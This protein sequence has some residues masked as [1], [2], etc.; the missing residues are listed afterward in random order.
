MANLTGGTDNIYITFKKP[1]LTL[2]A[3]KI[4]NDEKVKFE[5]NVLQQVNKTPDVKNFLKAVKDGNERMVKTVLKSGNKFLPIFNG[6]RWTQIDK[7][8]FTLQDNDTQKQELGSLLAIQRGIENNGYTDKSKFFKLYREEL[9][10]VYPEMN[11]KWEETFFQQQLTVYRKVGPTKFSH[12]SRDGGFMD[13]ITEVAKNNYG[14]TRKDTWNPADIWLVSDYQKVKK[15]LDDAIKDDS[16]S[17]QEFNEILRK[18][19]RDKK[20]IGISLKLISGTTAK[21]EVVN[22]EKSDLFDENEYQ[23]SFSS[24][25]LDLQLKTNNKEFNNTDSKIFIEGK[26]KVKF[27]IRQNSAG[28]NN[29]KIEGTDVGASS[30][31]LGKV[32]LD[33]ATQVFKAYGLESMR[34]RKWQNYPSNADEYNDE[35]KTHEKRFS[36]LKRRNKVSFGNVSNQT[37]FSENIIAVFNEKPDIANSKLMQLDLLNEIFSLTG[38]KLDS[39]LTNLAFL[40]QKKGDVFGPFAKLY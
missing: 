25:E 6:Y 7:G 10:S 29:L 38:D 27:Q 24:S 11:E 30:A 15:I 23:F 4:E 28:F 12:Y 35:R 32:P 40:A 1:Y 37:K 13:Y 14:I 16:T 26:R 33:L 31:R 34:W 5:G 18:M 20:I 3:N 39:L 19:F 22:L 9:F 2:L 8:Q 17:I 36:E 21:W